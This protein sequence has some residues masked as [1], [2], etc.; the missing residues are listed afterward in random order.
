MMR[1]KLSAAHAHKIILC[2]L[3]HSVV[4]N[5]SKKSNKMIC[6]LDRL[7]TVHSHRQTSHR[8]F[9]NLSATH[10]FDYRLHSACLGL[11]L[12]QR[13]VK[14]LLWP[15]QHPKL[16]RYFCKQLAI[17]TGYIQDYIYSWHQKE[18]IIFLLCSHPELHV[19]NVLEKY[20]HMFDEQH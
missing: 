18:Y 10:A 17:Y 4:Q 14:T 20:N 13:V 12:A 15:C 3:R 16:D 7:R 1:W 9:K 5:L 6:R 11:N 19:S 8:N 2:Y